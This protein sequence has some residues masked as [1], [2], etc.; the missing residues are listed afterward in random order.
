LN[1]Y[2]KSKG[3]FIV[4][5][6]TMKLMKKSSILMHPFPRV[7]EIT[8]DVDADSRAWYFKQP[9]AGVRTRMALL[10]LVLGKEKLK[11]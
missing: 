7:D 3:Q 6:S 10:G 4:T 11:L 2:E 8:E 1:E 5:P 9:A